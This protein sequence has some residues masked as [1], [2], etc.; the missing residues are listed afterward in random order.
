[1]KLVYAK[2]KQKKIIVIVQLGYNNGLEEGTDLG[3]AAVC[4]FLA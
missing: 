2:V 3:A 4:P 1:M